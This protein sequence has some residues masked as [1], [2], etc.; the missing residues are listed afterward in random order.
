MLDQI[1]SRGRPYILVY[2]ILEMEKTHLSL[3]VPGE[4]GQRVLPAP[5]THQFHS[6][7]WLP[8]E[9]GRLGHVKLQG[10]QGF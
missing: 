8:Q 7:T 5:S 3:F 2:N 6:G 10:K 9:T 4:K 1:Y